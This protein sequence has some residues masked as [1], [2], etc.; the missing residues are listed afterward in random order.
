MNGNQPDLI[1][2]ASIVSSLIHPL[3]AEQSGFQAD[4]FY[5]CVSEEKDALLLDATVANAQLWMCTR[6]F[7]ICEEV[8]RWRIT[9]SGRTLDSTLVKLET[10]SEVRAAHTGRRRETQS[11]QSTSSYSALWSHNS[12]SCY[13]QWYWV[14]ICP[15]QQN[16]RRQRSSPDRQWQWQTRKHTRN[17]H[18]LKYPIYK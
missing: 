2:F 14:N 18:T 10:P 16:T 1:P 6:K 12:G 17:I 5:K 15:A 7:P 13:I 3:Q 4:T 11:R 8:N 9:E